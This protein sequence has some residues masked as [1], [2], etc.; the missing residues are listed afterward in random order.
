VRS[1][2]GNF[3]EADIVLGAD[4]VRGVAHDA[5]YEAAYQQAQHSLFTHSLTIKLTPSL[6]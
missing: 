5:A 6:L 3:Q 2:D 1:D 4:G